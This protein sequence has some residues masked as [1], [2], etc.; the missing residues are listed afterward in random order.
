MLVS[1]CTSRWSRINVVAARRRQI[2]FG[3]TGLAAVVEPRSKV[4]K[5]SIPETAGKM[6]SD[7]TGV[8]GCFAG[9]RLGVSSSILSVLHTLLLDFPG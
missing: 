8:V 5:V 1:W 3:T 2:E 7:D 6:N 9:G 4:S